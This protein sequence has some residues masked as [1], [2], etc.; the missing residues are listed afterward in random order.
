MIGHSHQASESW[1]KLPTKKFRRNLFHLQKRVYK[2]ISRWR[3]AKSAVTTKA[4]LEI[5]CGKNAGDTSS[6]AA[7]S[8]APIWQQKISGTL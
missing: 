5:P 3:E 1:K 4:N 6:N 2:A 7:K 8:W